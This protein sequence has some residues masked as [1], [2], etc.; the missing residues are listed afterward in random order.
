MLTNKIKMNAKE[1]AEMRKKHEKEYLT[2]IDAYYVNKNQ[3]KA[4]K[5][6]LTVK[7]CASVIE[8]R[9]N[10]EKVEKFRENTD[11][12]KVNRVSKFKNRHCVLFTTNSNESNAIMELATYAVNSVLK[13]KRMNGSEL[14][15]ILRSGGLVG[16]LEL[17]DLVSEAYIS[18]SYNWNKYCSLGLLI[19]PAKQLVQRRLNKVQYDLIM[20]RALES[21]HGWAGWTNPFKS[22]F[23]K[24]KIVYAYDKLSD[25]EKLYFTA[26]LSVKGTDFGRKPKL[27]EI[28]DL[29]GDNAVR[30]T[31]AKRYK[32]MLYSLRKYLT[33]YDLVKKYGFL[34]TGE[35]IRHYSKE[36]PTR[37]IRIDYNPTKTNSAELKPFKPLSFYT[38]QA[39][40]Q[41]LEKVA[42]KRNKYNNY[43]VLLNI[44]VNIMLDTIESIKFELAGTTPHDVVKNLPVIKRHMNFWRNAEKA[45]NSDFNY[46]R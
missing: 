8:A 26:W 14:P 28:R 7:E 24:D 6:R 34:N 22:V 25:R 44:S 45:H 21:V 5:T 18:V 46:K 37:V 2:R 43:N 23:D 1:L 11:E 29:T 33:E 4:N 32:N 39:E 41:R 42:T 27:S 3:R 12:Y 31:I 17:A 13:S 36:K 35:T 38:E 16:Y 40:M 10:R 15:D 19:N 20:N 30:Q 9:R